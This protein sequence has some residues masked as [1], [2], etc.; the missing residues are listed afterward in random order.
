MKEIQQLVIVGT[1]AFAREVN[2]WILDE[3]QK[4]Q[5]CKVIGYLKTADNDEE[6]KD[7]S[8]GLECIGVIG[9]YALPKGHK[10]VMGIGTPKF[11]D[12]IVV[13]HSLN[14]EDFYTFIHSTTVLAG[15]AIVGRGCILCPFTVV[16]T[17]AILADFVSVNC[18]S[19]IGHDV[20]VGKYTTLS[21]HV[22]L[23][24]YVQVGDSVFFGS[25]AK[26][27]PGI[28]IGSNAMIGM[29]SI[30]IN[31]IE[32]NSSTYSLPSRKL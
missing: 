9:E 20:S 27:R 16:S 19:G 15:S 8:F 22:D 3:S 28:K 26:T 11:K 29:G 13:K 30:I 6:Q 31:N 10:Y 17:N 32:A 14:P 18:F 1:G 5:A 24:G 7:S 25:G 4:S 12:E 21:S 23:T 2:Q